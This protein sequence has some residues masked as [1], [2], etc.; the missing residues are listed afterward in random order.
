MMVN[1]WAIITETFPPNERGTAMG[2]NSMIFGLGGIIGPVLGGLILA[3]ASWRWIFYINI[4]VGV[5]GTVAGYLYLREQTKPPAGEKLDAIGSVC[6]SAALFA[7]LLALTRGNQAG[8][9]SPPI[10]AL[11]GSFAVGLCFFLYWERRIPFPALDLN[12]FKSRLYDFSVLSAAFQS[13]A[14]YSVQFL[15]V[16]YLQAVKGDPP[17]LAAL[18]LLP[19]PLGYGLMAPLSGRLSDRIGARIPATA[20][21]LL[22]A[23]GVYALSTTAVR[24]GYAHVAIGLAL[25]GLGGGLFFPP[26]TSSAMGA[27]DRRRLGVAAAALTTLRNT[28]MVVSYA[29]ALAVAA[30]SIP[31]A[32][33]LNLFIGTPV[34]LG[35]P[36]MAAFVEGMDAALRV[37]L[38][39]CLC[40]AALSY[41]RGRER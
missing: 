12:L 22:Q 29:S 3:F 24:S 2:I 7:L 6:F 15:V 1:S 32:L 20:G 8:W 19:M 10:L 11:L 9:T 39:L 38:V 23:A 17:I 25:T 21:L 16:F 40:A 37:S 18:L 27:A 36:L 14:T 34:L 28:G 30:G 4:P 31:R 33:M 41:V 35:A 26:N 5:A 13:L